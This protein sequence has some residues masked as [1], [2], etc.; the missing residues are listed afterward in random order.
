MSEKKVGI[1]REHSGHRYPADFSVICSRTFPL[2][3][4]SQIIPKCSYCCHG[5]LNYDHWEFSLLFSSHCLNLELL[6]D[7]ADG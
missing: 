1:P 3:V 6:H 2:S 4:L 7:G 5:C